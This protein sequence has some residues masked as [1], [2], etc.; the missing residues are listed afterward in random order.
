MH[1]VGMEDLIFAQ[2]S[3]KEN[4]ANRQESGTLQRVTETRG[5]VSK[6]PLECVSDFIMFTLVFLY[7]CC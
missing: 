5:K 4:G 7:R 3:L 2:L 6:H 1:A